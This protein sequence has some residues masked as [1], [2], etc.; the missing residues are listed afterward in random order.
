MHRELLST[1]PIKPHLYIK[2]HIEKD[3]QKDIFTHLR[4]LGWIA[5]HVPDVW[6]GTKFLDGI[7]I[8]PIGDTVYLE[9]KKTDGYTFN[10]SQFEPSQ[11]AL[12]T[13]LESRPNAEVYI[14][15]YSKKT[16]T[17]VVHTFTELKAMSNEVGGCKVFSK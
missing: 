5:Y 2:W 4:K 15:I 16:Q 1:I 6:L 12:L 7:L 17:Y 9:F 14:P 3:F 8:S 11:I 13:K 10:L